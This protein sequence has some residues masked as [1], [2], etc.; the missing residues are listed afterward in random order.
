MATT[1]RRDFIKLSALASGMLLVPNFLHGLDKQGM[2]LM[3][4]SNG[5][6]LVVIQLS[7]GNDGLNTVVPYLNDLYYKARPGLAI[8]AKKVLTLD[9]GLGLNPAMGKLRMLYDQGHVA[10]LNSVGYPDPD[11]SH[12]R[13]MDIWHSASASDEYLHTGWLGRYLDSMPGGAAAH[14]AIEVDDILSLALKGD[15]HMGIAVQ[16]VQRFYQASNEAFLRK[17]ASQ[18]QQSH[19][20]H[21]VDYLYKTLIETQQS[22]GYLQEKTRVYRSKQSYPKGE[23]ANHL[24]TIAELI[25]SGVESRVYYASLGGF[26]THVRQAPQQARLLEE[27]SDGIYSFVQDLKQHREF[28]NTMI[29]V[30]SE[31]GRRVA[32]NASAGTDHGT[33]NNLFL[34]GG[35]LKQAGIYNDAADLQNLDQ[36]D[37]M[38]K[39]DFRNIYATLLQNWLQADAAGI[40]RGNTQILPGLI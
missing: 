35:G 13:S 16:D 18:H 37:L 12:F 40:L 30:F 21:Q 3:T 33:A 2:P 26:D 19:E 11:R 25:A 38:Y 15:Q 23:F 27:L 22:A 39:I 7:G 1:S 34:I 14:T 31:F 36:G 20:H 4:G 24:K 8:P 10:V 6:R 28:D 32:Q 17:A 29:M 9:K 5:K